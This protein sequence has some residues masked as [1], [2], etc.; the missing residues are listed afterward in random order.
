MIVIENKFKNIEIFFNN[1]WY[2]ADRREQ[3]LG[4]MNMVFCY[5]WHAREGCQSSYSL[6]I[7][8]SLLYNSSLAVLRKLHYNQ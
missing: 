4:Y 3:L 1:F 2:N 8:K 7:N 5:T 6:N